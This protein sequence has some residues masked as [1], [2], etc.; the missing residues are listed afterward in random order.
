MWRWPP[1][2]QGGSGSATTGQTEP[3]RRQ[4]A[5]AAVIGHE[6][7]GDGSYP[8]GLQRRPYEPRPAAE[9]S[10]PSHGGAALGLQPR[11]T[12]GMHKTQARASGHQ[13]VLRVTPGHPAPS[14]TR[15]CGYW[16]ASRAPVWAK[17]P[18]YRAAGRARVRMPLVCGNHGWIA[19]GAVAGSAPS[20]RL[21]GPRGSPAGPDPAAAG[22]RSAADPARHDRRGLAPHPAGAEADRSPALRRGLTASVHPAGAERFRRR[23]PA[24][25]H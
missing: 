17:T 9:V 2:R 6:A 1:P 7:R 20:R 3:R 22:G 15:L 19:S 13:Q 5:Q 16:P 4:P 18:G 12:S 21:S 24:A 8:P 14:P 11:N 25:R 10:A 23:R